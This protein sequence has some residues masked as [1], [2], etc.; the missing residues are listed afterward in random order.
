MVVVGWAPCDCQH[1]TTP[2]G[3]RT[4]WCLA[5]GLV[6]SVPPCTRGST[7]TDVM[8]LTPPDRTGS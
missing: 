5:C 1:S 7:T 8:G 3:H 2:A 6:L 4:Y